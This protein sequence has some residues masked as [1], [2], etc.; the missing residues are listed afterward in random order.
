MIKGDASELTAM[1]MQVPPNGRRPG[2]RQLSKF[3]NND[4]IKLIFRTLNVE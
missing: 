3:S 1:P 2:S 4:G